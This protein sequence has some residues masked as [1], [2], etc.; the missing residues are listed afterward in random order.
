MGLM[1]TAK[2]DIERI[3]SDLNDFAKVMTFT[4]AIAPVKTAI[5]NGLHAK[6]HLGFDTNGNEINT[7]NAHVSVSE[8]ALTDKGYPVR[9]SSGEVNLKGHKV[10]VKDSTGTDVPYVIREWHQNETIGLIVCI[11]GDF[12]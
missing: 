10:V 4:S 3:T 12:E 7:E 5:V 1:E 11:L 6:H 2:A 9:D 8:K